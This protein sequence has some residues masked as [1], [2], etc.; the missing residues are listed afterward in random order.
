M[1]LKEKITSYSFRIGLWKTIKNSAIFLLPALV[2]YQTSV[3][4]QYAAVLSML[5]YLI[6]NYMANK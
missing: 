2:A 5:I 3:P 1:K 6:K 4:Q